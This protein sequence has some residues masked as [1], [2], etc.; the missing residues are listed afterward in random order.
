MP[1]GLPDPKQWLEQSG[2]AELKGGQEL[3]EDWISGKHTY[4]LVFWS[5]STAAAAERSQMWNQEQVQEIGQLLKPPA[6]E[7]VKA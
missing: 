3:P 4:T 6:V 7:E 1:M 5:R 2:E